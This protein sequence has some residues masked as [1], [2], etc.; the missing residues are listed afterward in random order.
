MGSNV[1][2]AVYFE[3]RQQRS[4]ASVERVVKPMSNSTDKIRAAMISQGYLPAPPPV[5]IDEF[6]DQAVLNLKEAM[7]KVRREE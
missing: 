5:P 7:D 2:T 4:A 3:S 1:N 6:I